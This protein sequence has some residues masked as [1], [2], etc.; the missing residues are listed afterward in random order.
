MQDQHT[1]RDITTVTLATPLRYGSQFATIQLA[2][3]A[4][5]NLISLIIPITVNMHDSALSVRIPSTTGERGLARTTCH[6]KGSH[7]T[8]N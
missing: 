6:I 8:V 1:E 4:T 5:I 3:P 7:M 2:S